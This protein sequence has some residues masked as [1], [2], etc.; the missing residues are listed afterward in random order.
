MP[1]VRRLLIVT[2]LG[3][4]AALAAAGPAPAAALSGVLTTDAGL[5][6]V[7]AYANT[8]AWSR[9]DDA[10]GGY[11]L[12]VNRAGRVSTLD[13]PVAARPFEVTAGRGPGGSTWL[14]WSRCAASS[15]GVEGECDIEGYDLAARTL[16][17]FPFAARRGVQERAPAIH[18]DRL[19]YVSG[20]T[21]DVGVVHLAALDGSEDRILDIL[22]TTTCGLS[23]TAECDA[24][25]RA[26]PVAS[27][28]RLGV[29][30]VASRVST[31]PLDV[32]ICG[33]ATVRLLDL[34]T[35]VARTLDDAVCGLSGQ[36]L[37][38][39]AFDTDGRLWWRQRCGG[40]QSACLGT[41]G[42]PF[43]QSL[44][45]RQRLVN[46]L[47]SRLAGVAV[48]GRMPLLASRAP[49]TQAGCWPGPQNSEYRCTTIATVAAPTFAALAP[50]P[51]RLPPAGY[52]TVPGTPRLRVLKPPATMAC[53]RGETAARP[54]ATLWAG[55]SWLRADPR[56]RT[57][58]PAVP[59]RA[60]SR[61]RVVRG[62]I[63]RGPKGWEG[64]RTTTLDLGTPDRA[65]ARTWTLTYRP[66]GSAA[67]RFTTRVL[68]R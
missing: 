41:R 17:A 46:A 54:G 37:S 35:G 31:G 11:R 3:L 53:S 64:Q 60:T 27:A 30:A 10:A 32:G 8:A 22:P 29:A 25:T 43:R 57:A 61:G 2:L 52:L 12:V 7:A 6:P 5:G 50:E 40:D 23:L 44:G 14:V 1:V 68:P 63:S 4:G 26:T 16:K 59:V 38:D 67:L 47:G 58:G 39:L 13:V 20:G 56:L 34:R 62:T 45:G 65:C 51:E 36:A 48:A 55:A 21:S 18:S 19:L 24:V 28:L 66:P 15:T 42:G 49:R 33:L 9:W